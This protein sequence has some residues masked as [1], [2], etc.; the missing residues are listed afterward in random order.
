MRTTQGKWR[1]EPSREELADRLEEALLQ[2][3]GVKNDWVNYQKSRMPKHPEEFEYDSGINQTLT[4]NTKRMLQAVDQDP[5]TRSRDESTELVNSRRK[6]YYSQ[7]QQKEE[8][9][10]ADASKID[11][12]KLFDRMESMN[13]GRSY[14]QSV[15]HWMQD[16]EDNEE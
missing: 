2:E 12:Q 3:Q 10:I 4:D 5:R 8:A 11:E 15:P 14:N 13:L 7:E 6:E 9:K 1:S 16:L